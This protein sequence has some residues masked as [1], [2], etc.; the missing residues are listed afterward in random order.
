MK[1]SFT[2]IALIFL[3]ICGCKY[4]NHS[5]H[6]EWTYQGEYG[7]EHWAEIERNSSCNGDLQSPVNIIDVYTEL[8]SSAAP[9]SLHYSKQTKI[10]DVSNNGHTI[11]YNFDE[12]DH[13][14]LDGDQFDLKQIHFHEPSEHTINGVRY[15]LELHMVHFNKNKEVLVMSILAEEGLSSPPFD[16]LES[17]LPLNQGDLKIVNKSFDLRTCLPDDKSY[18]SYIGSLTTPPCTEGVW[19]FVYKNSITVSL[20]QVKLLQKCMPLNNY[21]TEQPLNNRIIQK[22]KQ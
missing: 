15:P 10:H 7:P 6:H 16:F 1:I 12:G 19:W 4:S 22:V 2:A 14:V 3:F 5:D 18:Y 17:Y 8:D 20:E 21:R 13:V 9:L 11:Q